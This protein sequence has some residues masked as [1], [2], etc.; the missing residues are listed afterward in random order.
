MKKFETKIVAIVA[1]LAG[2]FW[3]YGFLVVPI[4]GA[5]G[6]LEFPEALALLFLPILA[7]PGLF[8]LIYGFK[9][10]RN[11][12]NTKITR[13][14]GSVI[15][16]IAFGT[17]SMV[18]DS[19]KAI[20]GADGDFVWTKIV[21]LAFTSVGIA[22][23]IPIAN[24][25]RRSAG[26][27]VNGIEGLFSKLFIFF[28]SFQVWGTLLSLFMLFDERKFDSSPGIEFLGVLAAILAPLLVA[29]FVYEKMGK[30]AGL[31]PRSAKPVEPKHA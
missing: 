22:L 1:V 7:G 17:M 26:I 28:V 30:M 4:V 23:Y 13:S 5:V 3:C 27:S 31:I 6:R 24:H 15:F 25:V 2:A 16:M 29:G 9:L 14:I 20:A 10:L 18:N 12:G 8:S 21:E 11:P 19:L